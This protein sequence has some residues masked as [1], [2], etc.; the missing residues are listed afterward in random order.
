[1]V[2]LEKI[3]K[4]LRSPSELYLQPYSAVK[5][6]FKIKYK[7]EYIHNIDRFWIDYIHI[8][9]NNVSKVT[10]FPSS[11]GHFKLF[12]IYSPRTNGY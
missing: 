4:R 6:E 8:N 11:G 9:I 3:K 2:K 5:H 1:M 10:T 12:V 7:Y